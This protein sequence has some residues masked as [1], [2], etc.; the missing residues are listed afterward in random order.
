MV[1]TYQALYL[2]LGELVVRGSLGLAISAS[3]ELGNLTQSAVQS[4]RSDIQGSVTSINSAISSFVS[5][6]DKIPGCVAAPWAS[7]ARSVNFK[8]PQ[9]DVPSL[10]GLS[11]IQLPASL[12]DSLLTLNNS[13]PTLDQLRADLQAVIAQPF[14]SV[15][16]SINSSIG[17]FVFDQSLLAVPQARSVDLCSNL[18]TSFISDIANELLKG[19]RIAL[20]LLIA[21]A[22]LLVIALLLLERHS[23]RSK[24]AFV[25]RYRAQH[26]DRPADAF[27]ASSLFAFLD[28]AHH[29]VL[30]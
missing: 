11:N 28:A 3:E 7:D 19:V 2:C 30:Q 5:T 1:D 8:A 21:A 18:D 10:D 25:E 4:V 20:A 9:F 17:S 22:V 16:A 26:A 12:T 24:V 6:V 14:D 13:L 29:P 15:K 27:A 23:F